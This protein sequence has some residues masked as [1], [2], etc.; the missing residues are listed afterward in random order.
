MHLKNIYLTLCSNI[1]EHK[2]KIDSFFIQKYIPNKEK[3]NI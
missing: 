1:K 3:I 2:E